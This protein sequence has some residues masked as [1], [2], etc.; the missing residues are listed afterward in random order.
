LWDLQTCGYGNSP[1][2]E[3]PQGKHLVSITYS[4]SQK[5]GSWYFGDP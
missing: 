3:N 1:A 4:Y 2:N 5:I